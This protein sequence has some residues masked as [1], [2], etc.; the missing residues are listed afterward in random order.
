MKCCFLLYFAFLYKKEEKTGMKSNGKKLNLNKRVIKMKPL[1]DSVKNVL[2]EYISLLNEELPDTI[3]GLYL[4][5]SIAL[6]A[7]H[8]NSSDIDFV[9]VTQRP[10][11]EQDEKTLKQIHQK[12]AE[13]CEK[14]QLDGIYVGKDNFNQE[15]CF[16]NEGTFGKAVHDIPVTWWILKHKGITIFGPDA[17]EL[18][19]E[20]DSR[21]L[22]AYVRKNMNEYWVPRVNWMEASQEKFENIPVDQMEAELEWTVLGLLRQFYTLKEHD[23]ISKLGAGEYGLKHFD[24]ERH[25]IIQ[26]AINIRTGSSN[27]IFHTN[28]ERVK[29][30][31]GFSRHL[32][33]FCSDHY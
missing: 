5:G 3:K 26:E 11:S 23:I 1:P 29:A 24:K 13:A 21:K 25:D 22:A 17:K 8:A 6:D 19:L 16:Y 28:K 10:L 33:K 20:A 18:P 30:A 32:I 9:A 4:H 7:Y 2:N 31:I 14:P 12:L 15:C 27:R